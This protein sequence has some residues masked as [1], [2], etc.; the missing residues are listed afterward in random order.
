MKHS[1]KH[2]HRCPLL[3]LLTLSRLLTVMW[4]FQAVDKRRAA[5][6]E[7]ARQWVE[8]WHISSLTKSAMKNK[9]SY[10]WKKL[11][12]QRGSWN[13]N[14]RVIYRKMARIRVTVLLVASMMTWIPKISLVWI[15]KTISLVVRAI[16]CCWWR[17]KM[18]AHWQ[19][20]ADPIV[21]ELDRSIH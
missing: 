17:V 16:N 2:K 15:G 1:K 14:S 19:L 18:F 8:N 20:E 6:S 10:C 11:I 5:K 4:F 9:K 21:L 12:R 13:V 3:S 7:G